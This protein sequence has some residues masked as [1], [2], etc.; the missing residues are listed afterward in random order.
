MPSTKPSPTPIGAH[1]AVA[2]PLVTVES[3]NLEVEDADGF[4][5]DK[6]S[7]GA[8]LEIVDTLRKT[9]A[10]KGE[11]PLGEKPAA[12]IGRK[13]LDRLLQEGEPEAAGLIHSA[14]EEFSQRL[15]SIIRRFMRQKSWREVQRIVVGGGFRQSRVGEL[16]IGRTGV[17]MKEQEI[18]VEVS[19]IRYHP[20]E[21]GLIGALHL[22]PTWVFSGHESI[23]AVDIGG[24]NIRCGVVDL[25]LKKAKD[26]SAAVVRTS[27]L[28]RHADDKPTRE[29]AI[30]RLVSMLEGFVR[31]AGRKKWKVAPFIGIGVPG[32]IAEDGTIE[33]GAQNLPGNWE[34]S[35]F[36]LAETLVERIPEI[37]G[38][39]TVVLMHNDAVVQGLSEAPF[40]QDADRWAVLTIGTGLGN[41]SFSNRRE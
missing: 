9:V 17:L 35:R 7:K 41:A 6:A 14:V 13:G 24:S 34:S 15:A 2:L 28:W 23:L 4:I 36:H 39:E 21:A 22:A 25:G 30:D 27:E 29:E 18:D 12:E 19:P 26:L 20:D 8:F 10:E 1:G 37:N 32:V 33:R 31:E 38:H 11:D 16:V 3:Y 5:G 40:V